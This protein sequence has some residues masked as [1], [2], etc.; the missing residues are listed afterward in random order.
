M[1]LTD[2]G[3]CTIRRACG[4]VLVFVA[5]PGMVLWAVNFSP[6]GEALWLAGEGGGS[7]ALYS[8]ATEHEQVEATLIAVRD[9]LVAALL[10]LAGVG[11]A[12]GGLILFIKGEATRGA[13]WAVKFSLLTLVAGLLVAPILGLIDAPIMTTP[14]SGAASGAVLAPVALAPAVAVPAPAFA[15]H[16]VQKEGKSK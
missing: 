6:L 2:T 5:G 1:S 12:L 15:S 11:L 8:G 13:L 14:T 10:A 4:L 16:L 3:D 7:S 9:S